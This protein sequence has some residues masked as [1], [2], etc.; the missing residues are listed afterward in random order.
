E[1]TRKYKKWTTDEEHVNQPFPL[2]GIQSSYLLG[3]KEAYELGGV[4]THIYNEF[5]TIAD[6][7]RL[8]DS[9]NKLIKRHPMLRAIITEEGKQQ[10]LSHIPEYQIEIE[11]IKALSKNEQ[12]KAIESERS[13]MSH[14]VFKTDEWPLFRIKAFYLTKEVVYLCVG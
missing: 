7:K 9:L 14:E 1:I 5:E 6:L 13:R 4:S 2:T 3:R 12:I 11:D 10:I 8:N